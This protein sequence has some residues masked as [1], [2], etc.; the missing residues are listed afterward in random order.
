ML[1]RTLN[2]CLGDSNFSDLLPKCRKIDGHFKHSP[3][4]LEELHQQQ[5]ALWQHKEPLIQ[6]VCTR[7]NSTL[8]MIKHL[9][10]NHEAVK[11]TLAIQKH[12]LTMLTVGVGKTAE[13]GDPQTMQVKY[14]VHPQKIVLLIY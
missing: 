7:W 10:K 1:Q 2:V 8:Y 5:T 6:D 11:A 3:A 12:K 4:N 9:L 14:T 13:A